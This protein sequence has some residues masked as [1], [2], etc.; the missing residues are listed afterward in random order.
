MAASEVPIHRFNIR[1][2][3]I[4]IDA[5]EQV[6]LSDEIIH[7]RKITKFPGGGLEYAEGPKDCLKR[8]WQEELNTDIEIISHF[9][10]TDF[11]VPSFMN[12]GSQ[13]ISI[14]YLVKPLQPAAFEIKKEKFDFGE[15]RKKMEVFR[16]VSL[17]NLTTADVTFPIDRK[18]VEMLKTQMES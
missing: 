16:Q 15:Q 10:T 6:L 13:V 9:Y 7:G 4:W 8:E 2:Y 12:D 1:V 5:E 17:D 3:G 18:V 14:Y 11:F